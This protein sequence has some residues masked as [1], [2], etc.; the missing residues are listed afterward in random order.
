MCIAQTLPLVYLINERKSPAVGET[1][2]IAY[3]GVTIGARVPKFGHHLDVVHQW[4]VSNFEHDLTKG[5]PSARARACAIGLTWGRQNA[6][7]A[8]IRQNAENCRGH[9]SAVRGR[10]D[11]KQKQVCREQ[12]ELPIPPKFRSAR[13]T[14]HEQ[15]RN[16]PKNGLFLTVFRIGFSVGKRDHLQT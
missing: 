10:S 9:I 8:K 4:V 3:C 11:R 6:K 15:W 12:S 1:L 14:G 2:R 13:A 7:I 16:S 5:T